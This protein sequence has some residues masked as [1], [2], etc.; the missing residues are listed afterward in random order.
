MNNNQYVE[1]VKDNFALFLQYCFYAF[2]VI[3]LIF[4]VCVLLFEY[5]LTP[6][7]IP[8]SFV[9]SLI[10][11]YTFLYIKIYTKEEE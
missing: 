5:E 8:G 1:V 2:L 11:G 6:Y 3:S 10:I 4:L 7:D 9:S